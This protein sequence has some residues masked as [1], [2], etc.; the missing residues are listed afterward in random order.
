M[1]GNANHSELERL[2]RVLRRQ[3]DL[4]LAFA[5]G[6]VAANQAG[7]DSDIDVAVLAAKPLSAARTM[8]L[9]EL[10]T[11]ETGRPVDLIDLREAGPLIG[12][13]VIRHGRDLLVR[14][15]T[16]LAAFI[17]RTIIDAADFLPIVD[18]AVKESLDQ[19]TRE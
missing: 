8:E 18:S 6:S 1:S 9:I 12:Q 4:L 14:S 15:N 2:S 17:S 11:S 7:A 13:Q 19:W 5:F 10:I 3:P 16:D